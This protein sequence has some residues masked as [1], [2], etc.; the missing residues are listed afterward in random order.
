MLHAPRRR[1]PRRGAVAPLFAALTPVIL[2]MAALAID[3]G[4]IVNTK[5]ELQTAADA[6]ALAGVSQVELPLVQGASTPSAPTAMGAA[7]AESKKYAKLHRAGAVPLDLADS[8][9]VVGYQKTPGSG[10]V[11]NWS[12][13]QP[14]P[15]TVQV[16]TR[17]DASANAPLQ[18]FFGGLLGN[19]TWSGQAVATAAYRTDRYVVTGFKAKAGG[20]NPLLLPIA[21]DVAYW[22]TFVRTGKSPDNIVHDDYTASRPT[23]TTP[24]PQNVKLGGDGI[25]EITDAYPNSTSPGNFGLLNLNYTNPVNSQPQFS[26]WILNGPSPSDIASFGPGGFQATS[27]APLDVK[28]GPGL[29]SSLVPDFTSIIGQP[30]IVPLFSAYYG[31]GSNTYYTVVGFAGVT[32]VKASGSGSN[33]SIAFEPMLAID[34]T[35]TSVLPG[36]SSS[37]SVTQFVYTVSP[38]SLVR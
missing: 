4:Y 7:S 3:I 28:G 25:P 14:F 35:A 2:A 10:T 23:S 32:V 21:V 13:G 29:K 22:Q 31:Q 26:Q 17:R 5:T 18:L 38:I 37:G 11:S 9:I 16:T 24:P 27:S 6:A 8:D 12:A 20:R 19:S 15:N 30:R 1:K 36:S 33:I 34:P